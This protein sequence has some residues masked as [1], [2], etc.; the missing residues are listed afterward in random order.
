MKNILVLCTFVLIGVV[1]GTDVNDT[2]YEVKEDS[3]E[4]HSKILS[5]RK[6]FLIFPDGSS[7]QLVFCAQNQGYLQIGDI[8]WFGN[9]AALAWEL[10]SDPQLFYMLK[11]QS[12]I[13]STRREDT[14]HIY[15]LDEA[16]KVLSKVPYRRRPIVNPAFAKR[17]IEGVTPSD[18]NSTAPCIK[19]MH[20][21]EKRRDIFQELEKDR[22]E[23]HRQSKKNFYEKMEIVFEGLGM[24]GKDCVLRMLCQT[25]QSSNVQGSFLEEIVKATFTL[26]RG[27]GFDSEPHKQYDVAHGTGG[28]CTQKYPNCNISVI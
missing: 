5:R 11:E 3:I 1:Y 24:H 16:G 12:K 21:R 19:D 26:P 27:R 8:V 25:A 4:N 13:Y 17:S 6:R 18:N 20:E 15:Y 2:S 22:I 9:T 23:F 28:D 10:P 7:F 14:K